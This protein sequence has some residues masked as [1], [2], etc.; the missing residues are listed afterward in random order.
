MYILSEG[1]LAPSLLFLLTQFLSAAKGTLS[2]AK[3][4]LAYSALG[5]TE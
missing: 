5:M 1:V 2:R 3:G 4:E